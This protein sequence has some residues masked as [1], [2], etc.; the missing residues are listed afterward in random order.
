MHWHS[1]SK[2]GVA[3][4]A[5]SRSKNG[6]A[7][8]A[9]SRSK[10]GVASLAYSRSQNGVASLAYSRSQNGVA[11]LAYSRSKNG[12]ASLAYSHSKNGVA[13]LAYDPRIHHFRKKMD[14]RVKPG[15]DDLS[16][17]A[18]ASLA[19]IVHCLLGQP[20]ELAGPGIAL[21]LLV[22]ARLLERHEPRAEPRQRARREPG[23]GALDVVDSRHGANS[24]M[25]S[26]VVETRLEADGMEQVGSVNL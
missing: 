1:R 7:S 8:L 21:D 15:N 9:Y 20:V 11:S 24:S 23:H 18:G 13:S 19:R 3:S 25:D 22:E 6:V 4:L 16:N 10:N 17:R 5:Y 14:C 2:N 26:R 12:V